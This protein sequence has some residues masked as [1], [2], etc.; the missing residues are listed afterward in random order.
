MS[1]DSG[2]IYGGKKSR[3]VAGGATG[4]SR[5]AIR[6]D[7]VI[8][9]MSPL[10]RKKVIINGNGH[11]ITVGFTKKGNRHL[12]SDLNRRARILRDSD[13]P[14]MDKILSG[15]TFVRKAGLY[16]ERHKDNIKRFY[17]YK[18]NLRGKDIFLHVAETEKKSG[19]ILKMKRFLYSVTDRMK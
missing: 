18:A 19:G 4:K 14:N 11:P 2:N 6:R 13:M 17:Y 10:L 3:R 1:G 15:S 9:T 8:G 16:K 5:A 7:Y 12:Y